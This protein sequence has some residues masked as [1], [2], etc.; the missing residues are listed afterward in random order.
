MVLLRK[1]GHIQRLE[2]L[3]SHLEHFQGCEVLSNH[4]VGDIYEL[5]RRIWRGEFSNLKKTSGRVKYKYGVVKWT[6]YPNRIKFEEKKTRNFLTFFFQRKIININNF[7]SYIIPWLCPHIS[8][9]MHWNGSLF[10]N[11]VSVFL[12]QVLSHISMNLLI[13][14]TDFVKNTIQLLFECWVLILF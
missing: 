3:I 9:Q 14:W 13:Q 12:A 6:W 7:C 1:L 5:F 8:Q 10:R 4:F 11:D 2:K